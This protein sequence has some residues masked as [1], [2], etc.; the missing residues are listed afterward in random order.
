MAGSVKDSELG[1][2][3]AAAP[4]TP[5]KNYYRVVIRSEN[6]DAYAL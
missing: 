2:V 3:A 1:L 4:A 6:L 5:P